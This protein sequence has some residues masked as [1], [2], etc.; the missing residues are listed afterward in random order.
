MMHASVHHNSNKDRNMKRYSILI[1]ITLLVGSIAMGQNQ[2]S[3][4]QPVIE[5]NGHAEKKVTPNEIYINVYL[6]E[7][8][9]GKTK[10]TIEDQQL[11][12]LKLLKQKGLN[13]DVIT[14][15]GGN[16]SYVK[17]PWKT[18]KDV[19]ASANYE[20]LVAT[21]DEAAKVFEAAD[22]MDLSSC[23]ISR[24][25]HSKRE[26]L[27]KEV[28]INAMK[29]AAEKADYMLEAVGSKRG[30]TVYAS[31]TSRAYPVYYESNIRGARADAQYM[32]LDSVKTRGPEFEVSFQKIELAIDVF[33]KFEIKE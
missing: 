14:L 26:E 21:A 17:I 28:R 33:V 9:D 22:E 11:Q 15:S 29:N 24:V 25:D 16:A 10:I 20:V 3:I 31:E 27:E 13:T 12:L 1:A 5:I 32:S 8:Y 7:R 6:L 23:N 2:S 4:I 19:L 30:S 18:K